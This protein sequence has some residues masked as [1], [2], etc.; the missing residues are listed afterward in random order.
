MADPRNIDVVFP[1]H[2]GLQYDSKQ[3]KIYSDNYKE[4]PAINFSENKSFLK[5]FAH[6]LK[7]QFRD[8]KN[9]WLLCFICA[10]LTG[11]AVFLVMK[12]GPGSSSKDSNQ[13]EPG[14]D[15]KYGDGSK[16]LLLKRD[17]EWSWGTRTEAEAIIAL[18]LY[19]FTIFSKDNPDLYIS[20][21]QMNIDLLSA[22]SN[23]ISL[24][25]E[26][27]GRGKLAHY[28][29]GILATCQDPR[30]FYGHNLIDK[31]KNHLVVSSTYLMS[32]KF[33]YSLIVIALCKAGES[34]DV[35]HLDEI[36]STPG[37][38]KFGVDE[39]AMVYIAY[40]CVG[41]QTYQ[42]KR[43][44][45]LDYIFQHQE[46]NGLFGNE[47]S[48][49]L[50]IQAITASG[51]K[52]L[53]PKTEKGIAYLKKSTDRANSPSTVL[54]LSALPA[55]AMKSYLDIG[56]EEC[57]S[58]YSTPSTPSFAIGITILNNIT[59]NDY[60]RTWSAP[61]IK[62]QTLF[63][64]MLNLQE[65]DSDFSFTSKS[66]QWGPYIT[67]ICNMAASTDQQQYWQIGDSNGDALQFGANQTFPKQGD[68]YTFKL[69]TW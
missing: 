47:F 39:A 68:S 66:T 67:S 35:K 65:A 69:A 33:S 43:D 23:D 18:H 49:S 30:N 22:L 37:Q 45:A 29:L 13:Y 7:T 55:I 10:V 6:Y 62:G 27:W 56:T 14:K 52:L 20:V 15:H 1:S 36:S 31:M 4:L 2:T 21:K 28:I 63:D 17:E 38:Y 26:D 24:S 54:L 50:A 59:A 42:T 58:R 46:R 25:N 8:V 53:E 9:K 34:V 3:K 51:D 41:D 5:S 48:T 11:I 60:D 61:L 64:A 12:Y 19:Q 16:Q 40:K 32:N 44:S 57:V